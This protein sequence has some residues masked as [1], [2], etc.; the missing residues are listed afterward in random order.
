MENL[1]L[2]KKIAEALGHKWNESR[3]RIC[4]WPLM[5]NFCTVSSCSERPVPQKRADEPPPYELDHHAALDALMEF[6]EKR[7][8]EWDIGYRVLD[9]GY[10]K[11][12]ILGGFLTINKSKAIAI[13]EAIKAAAEKS[14]KKEA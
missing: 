4:G 10:Y 1:E 9:G 11:V 6:C 5:E 12:I 2:R 8:L 13:C 14:E 7:R 3:C